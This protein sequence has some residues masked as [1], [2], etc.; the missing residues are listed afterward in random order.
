MKKWLKG[1]GIFAAALIALEVIA[2]V[3]LTLLGPT[4]FSDMID[5]L[6]PVGEPTQVVATKLG[7]GAEQKCSTYMG[8]LFC[9]TDGT[10]AVAPGSEGQGES[11]AR[12]EPG[13]VR[14]CAE[15]AGETICIDG[16]S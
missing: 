3:G 6:N 7:D 1:I 4:A 2:Y 11:V 15:Y 8:E 14:R 9:I 13:S 16:G 10:T 12:A 5:I